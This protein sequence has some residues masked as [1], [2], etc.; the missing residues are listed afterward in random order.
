[1]FITFCFVSFSALSQNVVQ[2]IDLHKS[3]NSDVYHK[4]GLTKLT[5][6]ELDFLQH[7]LNTHT[8][9][10]DNESIQNIQTS[11]TPSVSVKQTQQ[12]D[13]DQRGLEKKK[14]KDAVHSRITGEFSG[15]KGG[16]R[17]ELENGQVWVQIDSKRLSVRETNPKVII[18]PRMFGSW[19]LKIEGYNSSCKVE[20]I[21]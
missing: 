12:Q 10:K 13:S 9:I 16:T 1:M 2:S 5:Q 3:M 15:W 11:N 8:V 19:A 20:R 6:A 14:T 4:A 17:F 7:W 18:K 21:K